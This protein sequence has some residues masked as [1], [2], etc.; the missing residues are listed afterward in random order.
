MHDGPRIYKFPLLDTD[1]S[2]GKEREKQLLTSANDDQ[3]IGPLHDLHDGQ[4]L[5]VGEENSK[6]KLKVLH[7]PG[8]TS[9]HIALLVTAS[10]SDPSEVGT[11]FTGDAVLGHGTAVFEDL[12]TYLQ[13]LEK[14]KKAIQDLKDDRGGNAAA[15]AFPGHGAVIDDAVTKIQ[16][17]ISHRAMREREILGV[18][19]SGS[20][21]QEHK[22]WTSMQIVKV[23]YK[24][25]PESLHLAAEG[26]VVQ[27][28]RKLEGEGRVERR[29]LDGEVTWRL[30]SSSA[31][32]GDGAQTGKSTL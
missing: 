12:A 8:H 11:I 19:A 15:K 22:W 7:T 30:K 9:D 23:V 18:L 2:G 32:Q 28:L 16:E 25:V 17:Y 4:I 10:P 29:E 27:V 13:S 3:D 1:G 20:T 5:E 31:M 26:G 24:D 21:G 14:M 6:L